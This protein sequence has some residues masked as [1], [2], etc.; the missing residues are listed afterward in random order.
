[1]LKKHKS[2]IIAGIIIVVSLIVAFFADSEI[3]KAP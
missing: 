1:M 2:K 3:S